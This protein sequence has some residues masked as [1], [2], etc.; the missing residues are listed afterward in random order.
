MEELP[1][2]KVDRGGGLPARKG[3]GGPSM[4]FRRFDSAAAAVQFLIEELPAARQKGAILEVREVRYHQAE[5]RKL[6]DAEDY[7]L[8]RAEADD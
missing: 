8:P 3:G 6:Y 5:I 2:A 4:N 7:P 1:S